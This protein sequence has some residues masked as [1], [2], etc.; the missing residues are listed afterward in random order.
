M[1]HNLVAV[2]ARPRVETRLERAL[3]DQG[4]GVG[5]DLAGRRPLGLV[6][7]VVRVVAHVQLLSRGVERLPQDLARL[8]GESPADHEHAVLVDVG[9]DVAR[10]IAQFVV[11]RLDGAVDPAPAP[12]QSLDVGRR[13]APTGVHERLLR[14][15]RG[16]AGQRSHLRVGKNAPLHRLAHQ[17]KVAKRVSHP[18]PFPRRSGRQADAPGQPVGAVPEAVVPALLLVE[19]ADQYEQFVGGR[20]DAGGERG[21][22]F[23]HAVLGAHVGMVVN[24]FS[25][26]QKE[27]TRR[28]TTACRSL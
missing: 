14:L 5:A 16:D 8:R 20:I 28:S 6:L 9:A 4:Q 1:N 2:A 18:H 19:L 26:V 7:P 12:D 23:A 24:H 21:D 3:R 11:A 10:R 22:L 27:A 17:G 25:I 15:G 13:A